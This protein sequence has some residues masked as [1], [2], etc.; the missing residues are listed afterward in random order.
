MTKEAAYEA[1]YQLQ[2]L[3]Y[4]GLAFLR[5]GY[6]PDDL[7]WLDNPYAMVQ[8]LV[9]YGDRQESEKKHQN[10][11][12]FWLCPKCGQSRS[13]FEGAYLPCDHVC[14][15]DGYVRPVIRVREVVSE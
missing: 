4:M 12:E 13:L 11:R 6:K 14:Y 8:L 1:A 5:L 2:N 3:G 9:E 15:A 7:E 10:T